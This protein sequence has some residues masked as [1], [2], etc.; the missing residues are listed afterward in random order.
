[1]SQMASNEGNEFIRVDKFGGDNFNLYKF[2]LEIVLSAKDPW[3]IMEDL[4]LLPPSTASDEVK[5]TD[6]WWCKKAFACI[7]TSLL[8]KELT[9]IKDAK[10]PRKRK[11]KLCNIYKT[12]SLSN[13][14]FKR[15]KFFIIKMEKND[16]ILDHI[17]KEKSLVD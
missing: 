2:K 7:A 6:K 14:L 4:E 9:H 1:M 8:D 11:G 16:D 5:K 3:E 15:H 12:K 10:D 13:I 17:N